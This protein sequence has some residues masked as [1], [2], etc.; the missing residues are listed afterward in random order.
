MDKKQTEKQTDG[1]MQMNKQ[2]DREINKY[3]QNKKD[4]QQNK[5]KI[6]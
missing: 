4:R 3:E 2:T 6:T 1:Q 5:K